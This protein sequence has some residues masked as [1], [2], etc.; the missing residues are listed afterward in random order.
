MNL[1]AKQAAIYYKQLK[2]DRPHPCDYL[3]HR[4]TSWTDNVSSLLFVALGKA[5]V[6]GQTVQLWE[7]W[8]T[9]RRTDRQTDGQ[10]DATKYIISIASRSIIIL[11][12]IAKAHSHQA[13]PI[14]K[15]W[16]PSECTWHVWWKQNISLI[17]QRQ[18]SLDFICLHYWPAPEKYGFWLELV[19]NVSEPQFGSKLFTLKSGGKVFPPRKL[20]CYS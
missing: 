18:T 1:L 2:A 17:Y 13:K 19:Y 10:M 16:F 8:R 5:E 11:K 20:H 9:D 12:E 3:T 4:Q 6:I 14:S 15:C 7:C